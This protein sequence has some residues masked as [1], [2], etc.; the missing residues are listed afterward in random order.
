MW[1]N[2]R[3]KTQ[4]IKHHWT[5]VLSHGL[6]RIVKAGRFNDAALNVMFVTAPYA[7][8]EV[9]VTRV[10]SRSSDGMH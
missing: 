5:L 3:D 6:G 8:G 4:C 2:F 10:C 9:V 7:A 1:H